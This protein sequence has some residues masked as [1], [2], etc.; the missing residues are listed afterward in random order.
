MMRVMEANVRSQE[1]EKEKIRV[2]KGKKKRKKRNVWKKMSLE[3]PLYT[4]KGKKIVKFQF[5]PYVFLQ[6]I[7]FFPPYKNSSSNFTKK[8]KDNKSMKKVRVGLSHFC[9]CLP[10]TVLE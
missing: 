7:T 9:L 8:E 2:R 4:Q 1:E 6:D 3:A 5:Y 10:S